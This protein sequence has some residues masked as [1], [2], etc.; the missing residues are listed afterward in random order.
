MTTPKQNALTV[1]APSGLFKRTVAIERDTLR[2]WLEQVTRMLPPLVDAMPLVADQTQVLALENAIIAAVR[3]ALGRLVA[4]SPLGK[5]DEAELR[6][7]VFTALLE[8]YCQPPSASDASVPLHVE[9]RPTVPVPSERLLTQAGFFGTFARTED[10]FALIE[11]REDSATNDAVEVW[12]DAYDEEFSENETSG[13]YVISGDTGE[14]LEED[15]S[16]DR[17]VQRTGT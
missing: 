16:T 17:R 7:H 6:K 1:P 8:G 12:N 2:K 5:L 10:A 14:L 9:E 15:L 11:S 4:G 13:R 3:S